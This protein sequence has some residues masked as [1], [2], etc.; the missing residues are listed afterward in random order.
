[1]VLII[2]IAAMVAPVMAA[3]SDTDSATVTA[4]ITGSMAIS[5]G[6]ATIDF[7]ELTE[8][9]TDETETIT[10]TTNYQGWAVTA[11]DALDVDTDPGVAKP[12]ASVGALTQYTT[13]PGTWGTKYMANPLNVRSPGLADPVVAATDYHALTGA[14]LPLF[15]SQV[16]AAGAVVPVYFQQVYAAADDP[17]PE[18]QT[19]RIVVTF[20]AGAA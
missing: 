5:V 16:G 15:T 11:H 14:G 18:T 9:D 2:A 19:Y 10:V 6:A 12:G 20:A 3:D 7:G 1:M 17:L 4:D 13:A 8:T